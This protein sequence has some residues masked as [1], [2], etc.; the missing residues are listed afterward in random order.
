[1]KRI[2]TRIAVFVLLVGILEFDAAFGRRHG[3]PT[4]SCGSL[5]PD[6]DDAEPQT[7]EAPFTLTA[8]ANTIKGGESL[9]IT[10]STNSGSEYEFFQGFLI[11]AADVEQTDSSALGT[12]DD[13]EHGL[14]EW[15]SCFEIDK[16]A[17]T[18]NSD[19][20]K[21]DITATWTAPYFNGNV[22]F[23]ATA[24]YNYS[25]YWIINSDPIEVSYDGTIPTT[26]PTTP[27]PP[28]SGFD[29]STCGLSQSCFGYPD[30]CIQTSSC[31][32]VVS[33]YAKN[34]K[35]EVTLAG[36]TVGYIAFGLSSDVD[37]GDDSVIQCTNT[38]YV[39][40]SINIDHDNYAANY[41][42]PPFGLESIEVTEGTVSCTFNLESDTTVEALNYGSVTTNLKTN[43]YYVFLAMGYTNSTGQGIV[44]HDERAPTP[45]ALDMLSTEYYIIDSDTAPT[46]DFDYS[47]CGNTQ[48]CFGIPD[49]CV[50]TEKCTTVMSYYPT[51]D[52]LLDVTMMSFK[53]YVAFGLSTDDS[54]GEDSVIEC[55]G[56]S[57]P[58]NGLIAASVNNGK[59]NY[60]AVGSST[61]YFTV[62]S[63]HYEEGTIKCEITR[64]ATTTVDAGVYEQETD[65]KNNPYY[66][67]L[68]T[69]PLNSDNNGIMQHDEVV[70]SPIT[71]DMLST[72][73]Y[74]ID[75]DMSLD[76]DYS[77][78]GQTQS[79]FGIPDRCI[80]FKKCT[81]IMSYYPTEDGLLDVTMMSSKPYVAFGLSTDDS[82]GGDSIIECM[83]P[84]EPDN[85]LIAASVNHETH[86]YMAVG[87]STDYFTVLTSLYKENTIK[88]EITRPAVTTVDADEYV[89]ETD[90]KTNPYY[91]Q[92]VTGPLNSTNNGIK[93]HDEVAVSPIALDMLSTE[94]YII[95]SD[96]TPPVAFDYSVC[97]T[98]QSCFGI[99]GG[100][101]ALENCL[102]VMSYYATEDD[103][104]DVTM[105]SVKSYVAFGLSVDNSMGDDSVIECMGPS[106]PDNGRV[107]ASINH[108]KDNIIADGDMTEYFTVLSSQ[109]KAGA[110]Q[111]QF[112][113]PVNTTVVAGGNKLET[114]IKNNLYYVLLADGSLNSDSTD[115]E[116]HDRAISTDA[117]V[118]LTSNDF[119]VGGIVKPDVEVKIHGSLM[120]TAW[121][122]T[123]SIAIFMARYYKDMWP[124]VMWCKVKVW[125]ALHRGLNIVT[126]ILTM[127]AFILIFVYKKTL[128]SWRDNPHPILGIVTMIL[129]IIQPFGSIFRCAPGTPKRPL[130]NWLHW[131]LG[132]VTCIIAIA[133]IYLAVNL[134]K[135]YLPLK[136]Y[137]VVSGYVGFYG[138][139]FGWME[140]HQ[141]RMRNKHLNKEKGEG[142][143]SHHN[144]S[145][146]SFKD[147]MLCL[148]V[149]GTIGFTIGIIVLICT[150]DSSKSRLL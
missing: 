9:T 77:V 89:Q 47:V 139:M 146:I 32:M 8:S 10:L 60:V 136:F 21:T 102:T 14:I 82:M 49:R 22:Q 141:R 123:V 67:L 99:P 128:S 48:S 103:L 39:G 131:C 127:A 80:K 83:G 37:M 100:C 147:F 23:M 30:K 65:I 62:V 110:I 108:G 85:G 106:E 75:S 54:M 24:L 16:S 63:S 140:Y 35:L 42:T 132:N 117:P 122:G 17:L 133:T 150:A 71:F 38:E 59:H 120:V 95:D 111:C 76:F 112:T 45:V 50:K 129:A 44:Y 148:F 119:V 26:I 3:A 98:S 11:R 116:E 107:V 91:I 1:M 36:S 27:T 114:D 149:T 66:I 73:F 28:V 20:V 69:G 96:M 5:K 46:L 97:G 13:F 61:D 72:D 58:E 145:R 70:V 134:R 68:A 4:S 57:E 40:A 90:I 78:C 52:G 64:P 41:D 31:L 113:R 2:G 143:E 101:V 144:K 88:C 104:L 92:L 86:N 87:S 56:P 125:F 115:I 81:T 33:Y 18:H 55:M 79:C 74:I 19:T 94:F 109:Y 130:F 121:I 7:S 137:Y 53:P 93:K 29:Y 126:V 43:N 51:E 6:H 15:L 124:D 25:V 118:N 135:A 12:Y 34:D 105:M 138:F 84:S 142:L